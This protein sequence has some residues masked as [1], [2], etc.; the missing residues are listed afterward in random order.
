MGSI[1]YRNFKDNVFCLLHREKENLLELYNA[2]NGTDYDSVEGLTVVTL[3]NAICMRYR[4]DAA[5]TF[6]SD[7]SL[8]EQQ[9]T[10]NP[11]L[12][13]RLLHYVS[14]EYR[15]II[16]VKELYRETGVKIPTPHFLVF[17]N[18][19][20]V[21]P[22]RKVYRLSDLYEKPM[23][24]PELE[25]E[26]TVLNINE[27]NNGELMEKCTTLRGY[28]RF[29]DKVREKKRVM[30]TEEAVREAVEECIEEGIL[31]EFFIRHK[32]EV[33]GMG[34]FEFDE[35]LYKEAMREDG[36]VLGMEKGREKG[37]K[38]GENLFGKLVAIL[39]RDKM[40]DDVDKAAADEQYRQ[41]LYRKYHL[42]KDTGMERLT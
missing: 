28:M 5:Y 18:G 25:L 32:E 11:N 15:R 34:I 33:I 9:S 20:K 12:P 2:I 4:N 21:Q 22:E 35:E 19:T 23:E 42:V 7:L 13:L 24:H 6:N 36:M 17:Y 1:I 16:S 31:R 26:V 29:V 14:E 10:D 27:G 41:V 30:G 8:Y 3:P 39:M 37:R 40:Y 38:E